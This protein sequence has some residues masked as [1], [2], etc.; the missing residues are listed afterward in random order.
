MKQVAQ[1]Y[2]SGEL[3]VARRSGPRLQARRRPGP[4]ALLADLDRHRADEGERG[5][6]VP[7]GQGPG[8]AGPGP[9]APGLGVAAGRGGHVPQGDEPA[10]QLH[11]ARLLALRRGDRGRGGRGGVL[12]R[13]A[14]RRRR[15]RVRPARR[16]ELGADQ[17]VRARARRGR[18]GAR[19]VR[20]RRRDRHAGR[21]PGRG[22][23]RRDGVRDRARADRPARRPAAARLRRARRRPRHRRGRCRAPRRRA[24]SLRRPGRRRRRAHRAVLPNAPAAWGGPCAAR[25]RRASNG[26][27][28]VAARLARDRA[29]IVDIGKTRLDLP[30]NAYYDKELDV[31]FS[32]SYG[33]GRY[34]DRYELEGI[35]YPAGYVRW[36][37][38]RNLGCFL[39]L[40]ADGSVDVAALVSGIDP[41]EDAVSVY[42][43]LAAGTLRAS[44]SS[45][46][47]RE[48][49]RPSPRPAHDHHRGP[50]AR[51]AAAGPAPAGGTALAGGLRRRGQLRH[52]H[53][54]AAPAGA[55]RASS[56]SRSRRPRSLSG[57]QRAAQ[58][59][60]PA[61]SPPTST[62]CWTTTRST[63]CSW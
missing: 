10:R 13:A 21:A 42:D 58:V 61:P 2:R 8:P 15:Q 38:R 3:A 41:L 39:D 51:R 28:E 6:A 43:R 54:P 62:R 59:R 46:A 40:L 33:P 24:L 26:P 35:D 29:R 47:T 23:A 45:W 4:F 25:R 48:A 1:N 9:Q 50:R 57:A 19:R 31:R 20:H 37:E 7:G 18:A 53:A 32:R 5:P 63:P 34:D 22:R 14:R 60:L 17:P 49:R 36:T 11:P 16:G 27:V 44:G 30:W 52:V 56:W 55:T 12:G